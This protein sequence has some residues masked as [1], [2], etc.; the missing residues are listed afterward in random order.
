M[1]LS[2]TGGTRYQ[3]ATAPLRASSVPPSFG[4]TAGSSSA[5]RAL[6][7][8]RCPSDD[9]PPSSSHRCFPR[10]GSSWKRAASYRRLS[11]TTQG[12]P[13]GRATPAVRA[14]SARQTTSCRREA[15]VG[16]PLHE[17]YPE[18]GLSAATVDLSPAKAHHA[19]KTNLVP[20]T[21]RASQTM[22]VYQTAIFHQAPYVWRTLRVCL[23]RIRASSCFR[24]LLAVVEAY[25]HGSI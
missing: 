2:S 6:S 8:C 11:A 18:N 25:P 21:G 19:L 9:S 24:P 13:Q 12:S 7:P 4:P 3:V 17:R 14:P 10:R 1:D 22:P 20:G 23:T 5:R 16:R 15:F